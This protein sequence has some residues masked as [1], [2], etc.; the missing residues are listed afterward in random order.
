MPITVHVSVND[1]PI[2]AAESSTPTRCRATQSVHSSST[3]PIVESNT[4]DLGE[5]T[6]GEHD[7]DEDDEAGHRDRRGT[8]GVDGGCR[9][10]GPIPAAPPSHSRHERAPPPDLR[11]GRRG[12]PVHA[13]VRQALLAL[14]V[15]SGLVVPV[16][17]TGC[18]LGPIERPEFSALGPRRCAAA[19]RPCSHHL[20]LLLRPTIVVT[21]RRPVRVPVPRRRR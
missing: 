14:L 7:G 21:G 8:L 10:D 3:R 6:D 4:D 19:S 1:E 9:H 12:A 2:A 13:C 5:G 20:R 17:T 18:S 11:V 16:V 15:R